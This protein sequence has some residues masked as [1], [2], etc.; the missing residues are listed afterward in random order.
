MLFKTHFQGRV[1][2]RDRATKRRQTSLAGEGEGVVLHGGAD[3]LALGRA[4]HDHLPHREK[5]RSENWR[6]TPVGPATEV[7]GLEPRPRVKDTPSEEHF[8]EYC[9]RLYERR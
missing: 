5:W 2:A 6:R 4:E 7:L 8:Y 1:G 9:T 3:L